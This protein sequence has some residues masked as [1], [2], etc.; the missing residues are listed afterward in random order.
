[1]IEYYSK[2][3][4]RFIKEYES[5]D[6]EKLNSDWSRFIPNTKGLVLDIGAGS[7]RDASWL[8]NKG[9]EV[10]AVEPADQIRQKAEKLHPSSSIHWI[11]DKL[12]ALSEVYKLNFKFDLILI[13]ALWMHISP[14]ERNRSFRKVANLIKPGG[15]LI[16]T[17]RS[18]PSPDERKMYPSD[19]SELRKLAQQYALDVVLE[20]TSEDQLGRSDVSWTTVVFWLPDDGS[21]A[22][23]CTMRQVAYF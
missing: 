15:H 5:L 18:G 21:G 8:A 22:L 14:T 13:S 10:F 2:H 9:Q 1:M 6:P 17:L 16:I 20:K 11:K 7:G 12:P 4:D 3:A 23:V 19:P